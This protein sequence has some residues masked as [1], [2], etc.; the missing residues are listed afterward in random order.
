MDNEAQAGAIVKEAVNLVTQG[1]SQQ[2][3]TEE[4]AVQTAGKAVSNSA[5]VKD[6]R[7]KLEHAAADKAKSAAKSAADRME[8][9]AQDYSIKFRKKEAPAK[10]DPSKDK[11]DTN[12]WEIQ[13]EAEKSQI[14]EGI[15]PNLHNDMGISEQKARMQGMNVQKPARSI[16]ETAHKAADAGR[17]AA[18][19]VQKAAGA[20]SKEM[21]AAATI[22]A[23][24]VTIPVKSGAKIA[25]D[26][27]K[28]YVKTTRK[29]VE[30][31]KDAV[32]AVQKAAGA[33]TK[34]A[35]VMATAATA[36][37]SIPVMAIAS[38]KSPVGVVKDTA[39]KAVEAG[40]DA[41]LAAKKAAGAVSK[42]GQV[43]ATVVTAPVAGP[44]MAGKT[45]VNEA[46]K[47]YKDAAQKVSEAG[48]DASRT[49]QKAKSAASKGAELTGKT[50]GVAAAPVSAPVIAGAKAAAVGAKVASKG[51]KAV[52]APGGPVSLRSV[53]TKAMENLIKN[54]GQGNKE[55]QPVISAKDVGRE[56]ARNTLAK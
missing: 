54:N 56:V 26:T 29:A 17:D 20:A 18:Q 13:K 14:R 5:P 55:A 3:K 52:T 46:M 48:K 9:F 8:Q 36:P 24:P 39:H 11:G 43:A 32:Q 30:A 53:G 37:A 34:G 41:A 22:A 49:A 45:I 50:A 7:E 31:G 42:G 1:M 38:G 25:G 44:V 40:K 15:K 35:Q 2:K 16:S 28:T 33:V 27:A 23:S 6:A 19:A 51:V 10:E 12:Y 21:Q 47:T 4:K